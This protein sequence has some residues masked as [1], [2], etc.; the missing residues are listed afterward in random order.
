MLL[1]HMCA[2]LS[3]AGESCFAV[4]AFV[5][6]A[7]PAFVYKLDMVQSLSVRAVN[8]RAETA[9]EFPGP[10]LQ[11]VSVQQ[12][13]IHVGGVTQI[14]DVVRVM[15]VHVLL[16]VFEVL[17]HFRTVQTVESIVQEFKR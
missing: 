9:L 5:P 11:S 16:D 10:V 15:D 1:D 12:L 4:W 2:L 14:T 8:F 3:V 7:E 13:L 17:E 6:P